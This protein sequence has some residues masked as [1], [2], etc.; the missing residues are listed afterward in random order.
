MGVGKL[1]RAEAKD[2]FRALVLLVAC[3]IALW[4]LIPNGLKYS[5]I[6]G[7]SRDHIHWAIRPTD[8]NWSR[9]PLGEKACHYERQVLVYNAKGEIVGGEN[10]EKHGEKLDVP[11]SE[12]A[13]EVRI[14]WVKVEDE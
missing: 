2:L 6:Y 1:L 7:V 11:P 10:I 8:C 5:L 14:E 12:K 13:T 3:G 9:A 4:F